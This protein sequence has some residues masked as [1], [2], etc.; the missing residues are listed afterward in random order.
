VS[1]NIEAIKKQMKSLDGGVPKSKT[2]SGRDRK[3]NTTHPQ[4]EEKWSEKNTQIDETLGTL[5][6][7]LALISLVSPKITVRPK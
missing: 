7:T 1:T 5:T 4:T 3:Q 2:Q 6:E